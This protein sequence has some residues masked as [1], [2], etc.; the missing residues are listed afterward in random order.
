[1]K[2]VLKLGLLA[3]VT[4]T[5]FSGVQASDALSP[6]ARSLQPRT[7][8]GVTGDSLGRGV[9]TASPKAIAA[10][11][12]RMQGVEQDRLHRGVV[13]GSPKARV[14]FPGMMDRGA[15]EGP[16]VVRK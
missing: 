6:K 16:Q 10:V 14:V 15:S 13:L 3:F 7:M 2:P 5:L 4:S 1:M 12:P 9:E 8:A 11:T